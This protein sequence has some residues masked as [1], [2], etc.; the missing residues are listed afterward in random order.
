MKKL[1][2]NKLRLRRKK[3]VKANVFGTSQR[4]RLLI[5][6]SIK[7]IYTQVVDDNKGLI[8]ASASLREISSKPSKNNLENAGKVGKLIA[9]KCS[10]I[11]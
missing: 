6:R 5:F 2:R 8:L 1:S 10:K 9:E 4:P 7:D 11:K 3:R